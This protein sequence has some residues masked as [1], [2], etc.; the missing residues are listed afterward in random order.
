MRIDKFLK[1]SRV[2][3]RRTLAHTAA[4]LSRIEVNGKIVKPA[5]LVK[6]GDVIIITLGIRIIEIKVLSLDPKE[7]PMVQLIKE[8]KRN[9][10][11]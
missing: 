6:C 4:T 2:I 9:Q 7:L 1:V 10:Y 8:T 5:Y 3:K 11:E